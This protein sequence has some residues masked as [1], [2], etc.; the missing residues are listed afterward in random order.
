MTYDE[1]NKGALWI[2]EDATKENR[3]PT[4]SGKLNVGGKEFA[5]AGW[6]NPSQVKD[7]RTIKARLDLKLQP[8]REK[9]E[10]SNTSTTSDAIPF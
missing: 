2:N 9:Q 10:V 6:Y 7:G 3:K 4:H 8:P 5:L 1:T